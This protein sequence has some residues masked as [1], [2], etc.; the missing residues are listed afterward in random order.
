MWASASILTS[1]FAFP[2]LAAAG[3]SLAALFAHSC[4]ALSVPSR[5]VVILFHRFTAVKSWHGLLSLSGALDFKKANAHL[6]IT[7]PFSSVFQRASACWQC[8]LIDRSAQCRIAAAVIKFIAASIRRYQE[9]GAR[10]ALPSRRSGCAA[11]LFRPTAPGA[12]R[13]LAIPVRPSGAAFYCP[14][15][16]L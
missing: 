12:A 9:V 14:A 16:H 15:R 4:Q 8:E 2:P 6:T 1:F 3:L 11:R 10:I 13:A 7:I 5:S